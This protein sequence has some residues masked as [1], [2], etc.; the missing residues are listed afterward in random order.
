MLTLHH[1]PGHPC[2]PTNPIPGPGTIVADRRNRRFQ[3][4]APAAVQHEVM[5]PSLP[6][7]ATLGVAA[8]WPNLR[9]K[10]RRGNA[11]AR[12]RP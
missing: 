10:R 2:M 7:A 4:V 5:L 3:V 9:A 12:G 11:E 6:V 8:A 1:Q